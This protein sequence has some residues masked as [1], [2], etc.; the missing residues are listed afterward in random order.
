MEDLIHIHTIKE[1]RGERDVSKGR[2]ISEK[3]K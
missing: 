1:R 2:T 3:K